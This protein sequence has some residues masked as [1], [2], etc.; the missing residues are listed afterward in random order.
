MREILE[1]ILVK[2][3]VD[4]VL[5]GHEHFYERLKPQK[6]I[7]YFISG[8]AAKLREGN[9]TVG[10]GLTAK[11]FDTDN[12]FLLMEIAGD[13]LYYQAI[14]RTGKTFDSGV[15]GRREVVAKAAA[16]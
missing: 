11:A 15:L 10:T 12:H 5:A 6:G 13:E 3:G 9:V 7:H 16:R 4:L 2:H 1:P 8:G 14:S